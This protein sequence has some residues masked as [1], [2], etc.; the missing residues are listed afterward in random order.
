M[1][2]FFFFF[3]LLWIILLA[4]CAAL[5]IQ[6]LA[7]NLGVVTGMW[8]VKLHFIICIIPIYS[9]LTANL[10]SFSQCCFAILGKHLAEHC[11]NEYN[12]VPNFILWVLAEVAIV[13]CDIPE[14]KALLIAWKLL[15]YMEY[16]M[17]LIYAVLNG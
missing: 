14:G 17:L 6:S 15:Q 10:L 16:I 9:Y 1:L 5:I 7:A 12:K 3:Q 4:S 13:A 11:R 8:F 2:F